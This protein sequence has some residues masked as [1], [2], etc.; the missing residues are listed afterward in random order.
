MDKLDK[1]YLDNTLRKVKLEN[2]KNL[3]VSSI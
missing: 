1:L 2:S 3:V